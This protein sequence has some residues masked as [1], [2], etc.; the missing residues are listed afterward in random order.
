MDEPDGKR[1]GT[2]IRFAKTAEDEAAMIDLGREAFL[3]TRMGRHPFNEDRTR[4]LIRKGMAGN[5]AVLLVARRGAEDVG[6][7]AGQIG[8]ALF[9]TALTA[10]VVAFYVRPSVLNGQAAVKLLHAFRNWAENTG[11]NEMQVHVTSGIK[12]AGT[13]TF[14]RRIGFQQTGGNYVMEIG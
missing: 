7:I 9:S 1:G 2:V 11:A 4:E 6:F 8:P 3:A 13:D 5:A 12:M 10:T 14:M